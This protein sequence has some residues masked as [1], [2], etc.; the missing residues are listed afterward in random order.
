MTPCLQR[1]EEYGHTLNGKGW[2]SL[3]VAVPS[4]WP[5]GGQSAIADCRLSPEGLTKIGPPSGSASFELSTF[6]EGP[7]TFFIFLHIDI[8]KLRCQHQK[9]R[10]GLNFQPS[11]KGVLASVKPESK[12]RPSWQRICLHPQSN[13]QQA[14]PVRW[15]GSGICKHAGKCSLIIS[16]VGRLSSINNV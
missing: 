16:E 4:V 11:D 8:T 1:S 10:C 14:S 7:R 9:W 2:R 5:K 15:Q 13:F 12:A 6:A 3:L